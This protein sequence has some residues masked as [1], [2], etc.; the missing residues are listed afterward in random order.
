MDAKQ[1]LSDELRR[2]RN[3]ILGVGIM[4][5][6]I[7]TIMIQGV[8]GNRLP[9][10]WKMKLLVID[11]VILGVF[12]GLYV[13]ARSQPKLACVL[14]LVGYWGL[15]FGVAAWT[16]DITSL[17]TQGILIKIMFTAALIRG[18]KSANRAVMLQ[19]ELERVFG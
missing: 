3:W 4:M 9:S 6:V 10:E 13:L 2:A 8:Y 11:L 16:G 1:E 12:I 17:F 15:Q 14:A 18:L 5:F 7:D 19:S